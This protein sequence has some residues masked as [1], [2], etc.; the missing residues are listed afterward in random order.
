VSRKLIKSFKFAYEGVSTVFRTQR[1]F[2][3]QITIGIIA[4]GS[5][6][7]LGLSSVEWAILVLTIALVLSSE[8]INTAIETA[9]DLS[10]TEL[11]PKAKLAKDL[12]AG[13]VLINAFI[14]VLV[15]IFIIGPHLLK[16]FKF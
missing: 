15:G 2:R 11:H 3:I 8:M 12:S 7:F 16:L 9:V 13:V 14:A 6:I 4:V 1:N 5:A 10:T